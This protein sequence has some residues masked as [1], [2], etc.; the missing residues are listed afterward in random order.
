MTIQDAVNELALPTYPIGSCIDLHRPTGFYKV[1]KDADGIH[2]QCR[3]RKGK[4]HDRT[5]ETPQ[6]SVV[7]K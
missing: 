7:G 3:D 6:F 2:S 1:T 4:A 5:R